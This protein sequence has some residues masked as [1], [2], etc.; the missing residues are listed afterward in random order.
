[1]QALLK[2]IFNQQPSGISQ[3]QR[4]AMVDLCLLGMYA[5]A[6][7]TLDEQD[8]LGSEL[9]SLP[10]ESGISLSSYLQRATSKVR[11]AKTDAKSEKA[12]LQDISARLGDDDFKQAAV[13]ALQ[14]LLASDGMVQQ[15]SK[16]MA[17]V[18]RA[19]GI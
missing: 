13:E 1:M 11:E 12:L 18:T 14:K 8:F 2:K 4:E 3:A 9:D 5:D 10:W 16:F 19:I 15:E 6:K 7:L 17:E